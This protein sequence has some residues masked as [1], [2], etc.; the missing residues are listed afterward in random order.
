M[1]IK[2]HMH[3]YKESTKF[4]FY[5]VEIHATD[6]FSLILHDP[7]PREF[8]ETRIQAK[9]AFRIQLKRWLWSMQLDAGKA[10][11]LSRERICLFHF[12]I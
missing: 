6:K 7:I 9:T 2:F 4:D 12:V 10:K 1:P 11:S 3:D 5:C 8:L